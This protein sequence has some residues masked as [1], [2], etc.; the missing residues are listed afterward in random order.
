MNRLPRALVVFAA[1]V[2]IAEVPGRSQQATFEGQPAVVLSND[3][4]EITLTTLGST[5]ASIVL[6]EDPAKLNP[7][8]DPVRIAR[9]Q[10]REMTF[11]GSSGHFVCVD[12]FG[13]ASPEE[14]S[15]GMPMHGEAHVT[16]FATSPVR[17]SNGSAV[18]FTATL[19]IVQE[20]LTRTYRIVNGENIV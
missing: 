19:P 7:L 13:P 2:A 15:A 6:S 16:Q 10:G 18:T 14:R 8:W 20:S 1:L 17:E 5:L 11:N 12:G 4:L 3:K 9:E